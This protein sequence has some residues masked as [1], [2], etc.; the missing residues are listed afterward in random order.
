MSFDH[1]FRDICD[2]QAAGYRADAARMRE[3]RHQ[4]AVTELEDTNAANLA[5]KAALRVALGRYAPRH[6]LLT[7]KSLQERIQRAGTMALRHADNWDAARDA[8]ATFKY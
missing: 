6:P 4:A 1:F 3:K 5:E 8:G 2:A 7:D